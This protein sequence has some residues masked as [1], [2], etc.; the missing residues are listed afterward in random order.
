MYHQLV[1]SHSKST[2]GND[3]KKS[4]EALEDAGGCKVEAFRAPGFSITDQC[5][6]AFD[7]LVSQG[8]KIDCSIFPAARARWASRV[9]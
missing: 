8:F 6:W 7:E 3:L 9:V 2:F 4:R 1:F 5:L